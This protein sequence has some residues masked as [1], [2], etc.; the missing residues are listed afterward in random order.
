VGVSVRQK[1]PGKGNPYW[2]FVRH[3]G[4]RKS[5]KIGDRKTAEMVAAEIRARL[6]L[7]SM[8][9]EEEGEKPL[10]ESYATEWIEGYAKAAC[11]DSTSENYESIIRRHLV[12]AFKGKRL[13][14]IGRMDVKEL[15]IAK[16]GEGLKRKTIKNIKLCLSTIFSSAVEDELVEINPLLQLGRKTRNLLR[17]KGEVFEIDP[18]TREEVTAFLRAVQTHRPRYFPFFLTAVRTGMR[19]GAQAGRYR[20]QGRFYRREAGGRQGKS[21]DTEEREDAADRYVTP[22]RGRPETASGRDEE[23]DAQE[24]MGGAARVALL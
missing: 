5:K 12:P 24:R 6:V 17:G 22:A 16:I 23:G 3:N 1:Q 18:F 9:V 20:L 4:R 21:H 11:K 7:G 13:G 14:E 10:F 8:D 19:L 15:I 2:I